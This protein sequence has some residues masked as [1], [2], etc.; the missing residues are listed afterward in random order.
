MNWKET[1]FF[2]TDDVD[3][4]MKRAIRPRLVPGSVLDIGCGGGRLIRTLEGHDYW[5]LDVSPLG[6][7]E[8]RLRSE[9]PHQVWES[10]LVSYEA[11]MTW[12]N[13]LAVVVLQHVAPERIAAVAR[14]V[15]AWAKNLVLVEG[16]D[17]GKDWEPH[18]HKHDYPALFDVVEKENLYGNTWILTARGT[19]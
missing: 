9:N 6:V 5:G 3:P 13:L 15:S 17:D 10:D 18:C 4:V 8:A 14:K 12:D 16:M 1:L 11:E 2:P 7:E 19:A